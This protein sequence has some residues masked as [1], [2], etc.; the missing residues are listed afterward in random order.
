MTKTNEQIQKEIKFRA[1]RLDNNEFVIGYYLPMVDGSRHFI[2]L[3]LDYLNEHSR[4]EIDPKT[5]GQW[6]GLK[7]KNGKEIYENDLVSIEHIVYQNVEQYSSEIT[8][9]Y[10]YI[11][12]CI[13]KYFQGRFVFD[14]G[15]ICLDINVF[16]VRGC[17]SGDFVRKKD[18]YGRYFKDVFT[19]LELTG[20][21]YENPELLKGGE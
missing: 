9:S 8:E 6:T 12:K 10:R 5:L 19:F 15:I 13:C 20:N 18:E 21:I 11:A 16:W 2:Y 1:K 17:A 4:I 3:P 14:N 7:D